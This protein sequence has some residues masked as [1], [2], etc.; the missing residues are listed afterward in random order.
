MKKITWCVY[1]FDKNRN[2]YSVEI[3]NSNGVDNMLKARTIGI[4]KLKTLGCK[5]KKDY[6]V[7][8]KILSIDNA[9]VEHVADF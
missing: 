5:I 3:E 9:I 8:I 7:D 2:C 6:E 4:E 1:W